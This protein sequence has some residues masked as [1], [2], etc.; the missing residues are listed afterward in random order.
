ME[1]NLGSIDGKMNVLFGRSERRKEDNEWDLEGQ[2][3]AGV[4]CVWLE[5]ALNEGMK[6]W[7]MIKMEATWSDTSDWSDR[8]WAEVKWET[9][10]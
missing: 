4:I 9:W 6:T 5:S 1:T 7:R 8:D 2:I 10:A 3:E